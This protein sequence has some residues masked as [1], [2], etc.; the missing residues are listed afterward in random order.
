MLSDRSGDVAVVTLNRPAAYNAVG[1]QLLTDLG[2]A[3]DACSGDA[4]AIVLAGEGR[5]F[6]VGADLVE[7]WSAFGNEGRIRSFLTLF[8]QIADAIAAS[9]VPV[10]AAVQGFALAGGLELA[11]ACDL[12]VAADNAEFGDQHINVGL[13][14]GGGGSQRLPRAIGTRRSLALQLTGDRIDAQHALSWGLVHSV[15]PAAALLEN[16]VELAMRIATRSREAVR[17]MRELSR[18]ASTRPLDQ[19]LPIELATAVAHM[20]SSD[21]PDALRRFTGREQKKEE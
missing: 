21:L 20:S 6:C 7:V 10:I 14:P 4:H 13:I 17:R 12:I 3:L 19:G 2:A 1:T 8:H 9:P 5:H 15:H 16:A 18:V 11:L